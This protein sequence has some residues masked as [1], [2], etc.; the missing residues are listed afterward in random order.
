ME[1]LYYGTVCDEKLYNQILKISSNPYMVA[2][3]SFETAL[4]S[5]II[6]NK[7]NIYCQYIPQAPRFPIFKKIFF[8]RET[9]NG[10]NNIILK[11]IP[12]INFPIL[13]FLSIF[14]STLIISTKWCVKNYKEENKL[15][16]S[17]INYLPVSFANHIVARVFSIKNVC[18]FTDTMEFRNLPERINSYSFLKRILWPYYRKIVCWTE[19]EYKGYILFSKYMNEIVNLKK[20][21]FIVVEGIFNEKDLTFFDVTDRKKAILFA[22]SLFKQYGVLKIIEAFNLMPKLGYELW[23]AGS[24]ELNNEIIEKMRINENIKYFGFLPRNK[25]F[26]LEQ[27]ASLLINIRDAKES[28]TRYSF[29]SK[30]LEYLASGTPVLTSRLSGIPNEY[31]EY[32]FFTESI[33]PKEIKNDIMRILNLSQERRNEIGIVN[34]QFILS[35]KNVSNQTRIILE[36]LNEL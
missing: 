9:R 13:K 34:R 2:Q 12:T 31:Y 22:G 18:I 15:L 19:N 8:F 1:I 17:S 5:E 35:Q 3:Y 4:L 10:I 6:K 26:Q 21:P 33:N 23:I 32:L 20:R 28:F 25:V 16:L 11:Y 24:G 30:L 36:F 14:V 29:P 7:L 27:S